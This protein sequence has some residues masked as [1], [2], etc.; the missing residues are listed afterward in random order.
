MSKAFT[1]ENDDAEP[2]MPPARAEVP[3]GGRRLITADGAERLQGEVAALEQKR[4]RL[5]ETSPADADA[6]QELRRINARR[7]A[8][9]ETLA[10]ADVVANADGATNEV[11]FGLFVTIRHEDGAEDEYRL[12]GL[13]E[14]DPE[15]G[16]I[17]W[18]SPLA[19]ALLGRKAGDVVRFHAPVGEKVLKIVRIRSGSGKAG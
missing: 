18:L 15:S 16:L 7:Q 4:V 8:I 5:E 1:R 19:Q 6:R 13:N 17:S 2:E 11:R 3:S 12:V 14:V 10:Q 9:A